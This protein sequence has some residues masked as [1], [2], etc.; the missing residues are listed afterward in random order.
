MD[1]LRE[2]AVDRLAH[3]VDEPDTGHRGAP[4]S[5][6]RSSDTSA[7]S[8]SAC[9]TPPRGRR[10]GGGEK[11][12]VPAE[13]ARP[14]LV[15]AEE[16]RLLRVRHDDAG[17]AAS[18]ACRVV[19]AHFIA[20]MITKSGTA[21]VPATLASPTRNRRP[22]RLLR[23][24]RSIG[25]PGSRRGRAGGARRSNALRRVA[26]V[27]PRRQELHAARPVHRLRRRLAH[28]ARTD[29]VPRLR[30]AC[31]RARP[32]AVQA[33]L[34]GHRCHVALCLPAR[35]AA[36]TPSSCSSRMPCC[37]SW[38]CRSRSRCRRRRSA[39]WC[40]YPPFGTAYMDQDAFLFLLVAVTLAA[41]ALSASRRNVRRVLWALAPTAVLAAALTKPL[42]G[43]LGVPLVLLLAATADRARLRE[44]FVWL[45]AGL[46][47]VVAFTAAVLAAAGAEAGL[48][49]LSLLDLPRAVAGERRHN[50]LLWRLYVPALGPRSAAPRLPAGAG[51]RDRRRPRR[52]APAHLACDAAARARPRPLSRRRALLRA[53]AERAPERRLLRLRVARARRRAARRGAAWPGAARRACRRGRDPA[54]GGARRR[55][56]LH[57]GRQRDAAR[58]GRGLSRA[59]RRR[60]ACAA[61]G[62]LVPALG[63]AGAL[64]LRP[65][66]PDPAR[67]RPAP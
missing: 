4:A 31:G 56:P 26:H 11:R 52:T 14:M 33:A 66:R 55:R 63:S 67:S 36:S 21:R 8:C 43:A 47:A 65:R 13:P 25:R 48:V 16:V 49:R 22:Q 59:E 10:P 34:R 6:R 46:V 20:P 2:Q 5:A 45:A 9:S 35:G 3:H 50:L 19:V 64:P 39:A 24:A 60:A 40:L 54:R 30:D 57:G 58:P 61:A 17:L 51:V 62:A 41:G 44:A 38:R 42:P 12:R 18:C 27:A 32:W 7:A 53:D 29:A 23:R 28:A 37:G 15:V 1:V